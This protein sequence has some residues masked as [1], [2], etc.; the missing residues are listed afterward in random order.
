MSS[1]KVI[2]SDSHVIEPPDLWTSRIEPK[3]RDRAPHVVSEE[4]A[5]WWYTDGRRGQSFGIGAQAGRRFEEPEKVTNLDRLANIPPAGYIPEEHVKAMDIDGIDAGIVYPTC[6]LVLY[7][8]PDGDLL[9]AI[10]RTYNDWVAE[11][12]N[13]FPKRLRGIGAL[14]TDDIQSGV[15]ELERCAKMGL[16]GAIIPVY[17]PE[18]RPYDSPEYEPL[19]AAAQDLG[20]PLALHVATKR[21]GAGHAFSSLESRKGAHIVTVD[22]FARVSLAHIILSGVFERHPKLQVGSVE[23][24]LAWI[25]HLLSQMDYRYTQGTRENFPYRFSND[26]LPSDFFHRNVFLG[27]QEDGLGIQMRH[28]IGLDNILWGSDYPHHESTFPKS[29]EILEE[30]LSDCTEEEKAKIAGANAARIYHL[31]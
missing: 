31:D 6:S 9:T 19:W 11:F 15:E 17:P 10:F 2:S 23:H 12:C 24:E 5:D 14:N 26:M 20:M 27:F 16:V 18:D 3:Y 22:Y 29:R 4:D 1:Y 28:I 25:P 8:V 30:I 21:P 13:A 7:S